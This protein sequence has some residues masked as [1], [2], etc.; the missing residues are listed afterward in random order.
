[1]PNKQSSPVLPGKGKIIPKTEPI[2]GIIAAIM[3]YSMIIPIIILDIWTLLYQEV[4]F[5]IMMIPKIKRADYIIIDRYKLNK[6]N[7]WQKLNCIYCGYANGVTAWLKAI[8]NQTELY[9]CAIKHKYET[10]GHEHQKE[11]YEY[12]EYK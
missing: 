11:F 2:E 1:M 6:L 4:Y 3:I 8:S 12:E 10:K 7:P 5:T 9:S